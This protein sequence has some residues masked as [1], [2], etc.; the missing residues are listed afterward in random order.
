MTSYVSDVLIKREALVKYASVPPLANA[1][2]LDQ[3]QK[4][5]EGRLV[6]SCKNLQIL[7]NGDRAQGRVLGGG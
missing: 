5:V 2:S 7:P 6:F 1:R 4:M 3:L